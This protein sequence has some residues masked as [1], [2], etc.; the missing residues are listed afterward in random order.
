MIVSYDCCGMN[1]FLTY[2]DHAWL[3]LINCWTLLMWVSCTC[4]RGLW[5]WTSGALFRVLNLESSVDSLGGLEEYDIG[6]LGGGRNQ[7]KLSSRCESV[8][9]SG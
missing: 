9:L 4:L 6:C 2:F 7:K 5:S 8:R 1:L 3:S